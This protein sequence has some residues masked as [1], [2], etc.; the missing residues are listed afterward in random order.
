MEENILNPKNEKKPDPEIAK[1][2]KEEQY[3]Q[4]VLKNEDFK[5]YLTTLQKFCQDK[6]KFDLKTAAIKG[7]VTNY[8]GNFLLK[9]IDKISA[10]KLDD[11]VNN[12]G[13]QTMS[14]KSA[15]LDYR[16]L[17]NSLIDKKIV[18]TSLET[19]KPL[20]YE[21]NDDTASLDVFDLNKKKRKDNIY[22]KEPLKWYKVGIALIYSIY[23]LIKKIIHKLFIEKKEVTKYNNAIKEATAR[24]VEA[25]FKNKDEEAQS[26]KNRLNKDK[27]INKSDELNPDQV[28]EKDSKKDDIA[29][30]NLISNEAKENEIIDDSKESNI[31]T[32]EDN[33]ITNEDKLEEINT[34]IKIE[35]NED[36]KENDNSI[37]NELNSKEELEDSNNI[38]NENSSNSN[39]LENQE[40]TETKSDKFSEEEIAQIEAFFNKIEKDPTKALDEKE[41]ENLDFLKEMSQNRSDFKT[42]VNPTN[43]ESLP[44]ENLESINASLFAEADDLSMINDMDS[45]TIQAN[46]K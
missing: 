12:N 4:D 18:F 28:I 27:P 40:K 44:N 2:Q 25:E 26:L 11:K 22:D 43:L 42:L 7:L 20:V 33:K 41:L 8:D 19:K 13:L 46:N 6:Y 10:D 36:L 5:R 21:Y 45:K 39:E 23:A 38:I 24:Y 3:E 9:G 31:I 1:A 32:N 17:Y 16:K 35:K 30:N 29:I 34:D 14:I 15:K 37:N